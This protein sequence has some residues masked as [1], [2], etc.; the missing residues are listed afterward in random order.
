MLDSLNVQFI[1]SRTSI[2]SV[3]VATGHTTQIRE[4]PKLPELRSNQDQGLT[5]SEG[6]STRWKS[7]AS[8]SVPGIWYSIPYWRTGNSVNAAVVAA[9]DAKKDFLEECAG[10]MLS[11]TEL[12]LISIGDYGFEYSEAGILLAQGE[13]KITMHLK[14][15]FPGFLFLVSCAVSAST[16]A[17]SESPPSPHSQLVRANSRPPVTAIVNFLETHGGDFIS[18]ADDH[19]FV[20]TSGA[21]AQAYGIMPSKVYKRV[22]H[23][24][25][26]LVPAA[27]KGRG[28]V[29][30]FENY[31]V[32]P[33]Q[34]QDDIRITLHGIEQYPNGCWLDVDKKGKIVPG[35]S[36]VTCTSAFL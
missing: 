27:D 22:R 24:V 19:G 34:G 4:I 31:F 11:N 26:S 35:M 5:T 10:P 9:A 21:E 2:L 20:V 3:R 15:H 8:A 25:E 14:F 13:R 1:T 29:L 23:A 7:H 32:H 33:A 6:C 12:R 18:F 28:L 30:G 36:G 17:S 16:V